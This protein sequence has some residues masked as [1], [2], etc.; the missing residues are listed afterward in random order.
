MTLAELQDG[1][2]VR[3]RVGR[4]SMGE[5][6]N[7]EEWQTGPLFVKRLPSGKIFSIVPRGVETAEYGQG[8]YC[9]EGVFHVE[10]YLFEIEGLV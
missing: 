7:W 5:S 10:D 1:M 8:D 3:F 9:G 6:P 4:D 2:T